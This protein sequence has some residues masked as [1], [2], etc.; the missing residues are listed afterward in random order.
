[1]K[2]FIS[3]FLLILAVPLFGHTVSEEIIVTASAAP[4]TLQSTPAAVTVISREDIEAREA[5]DVS[6]VL[7]EVPGLSVSR[8]GSQGKV[9]AIFIRGGSSKQAL[10]LWNG[11]EVNNAYFSA[12]NFGQLSSAGVER[13]EI[14]RGPYSA[15]YGAD[16]VS[17]V[18]NILTTPPTRGL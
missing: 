8:T 17:G 13:V 14:V 10:V 2:Q 12:Y 18:I 15:L 9:S 5:R 16:A 1:M 6:D 11:V 4:E 3:T 7:R